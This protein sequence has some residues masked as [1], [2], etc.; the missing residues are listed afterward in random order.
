M[1]AGTDELWVVG[2]CK[3]HEPLPY[4]LFLFLARPYSYSQLL[5]H[6]SQHM[7][8]NPYEV[9]PRIWNE[10]HELLREKLRCEA[11]KA[12]ALEIGRMGI[13]LGCC[14]IFAAV[15]ALLTEDEGIESS[16]ARLVWAAGFI[17][18]GLATSYPMYKPVRARLNEIEAILPTASEIASEEVSDEDEDSNELSGVEEREA[19]GDI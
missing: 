15:M 8:T 5:P 18:V 16:L 11:T 9:T 7:A 6:N 17:V 2:K 4:A 3:K 1:W 14:M 10:W 13:V 19:Q 12:L